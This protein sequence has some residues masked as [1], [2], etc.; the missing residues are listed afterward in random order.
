MQN[1]QLLAD[2]LMKA[3]TEA[4]KDNITQ[5]MAGVETLDEY[6]YVLG[7]IHTIGVFEERIAS[8]LK[9]LRKQIYGDEDDN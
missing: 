9:I 6:R 2:R 8:E 1:T 5:L 4:R 7:S 3:C